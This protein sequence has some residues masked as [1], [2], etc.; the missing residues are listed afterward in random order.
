LTEDYRI[1]VYKQGYLRTTSTVYD[2]K[3]RDN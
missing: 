1:F 3:N 2:T